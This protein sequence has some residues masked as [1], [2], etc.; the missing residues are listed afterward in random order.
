[1]IMH[2]IHFLSGMHMQE[3]HLNLDNVT[4]VQQ[5]WSH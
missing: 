5:I 3:D 4:N 1:M 2:V